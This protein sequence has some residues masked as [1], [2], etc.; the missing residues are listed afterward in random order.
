M[1][2]AAIDGYHGAVCLDD[3]AYQP[4][5]LLSLIWPHVIDAPILRHSQRVKPS[6]KRGT[7]GSTIV[8]PS[9]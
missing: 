7:K 6:A 4:S 8:S 1:D 2:A 5:F 3:V 9:A